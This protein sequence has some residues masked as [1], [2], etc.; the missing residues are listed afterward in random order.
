MK[1]TLPNGFYTAL[2]TPL[3]ENGNILPES[4][5]VQIQMQ[6][7]AGAAGFLVLGS[8]GMQASVRHDQCV[9]AVAT[10][11][12]V[13]D[14]WSAK[15]EKRPILLAGVMDNS[16]ARVLD[17]IKM[18][19][20]LSVDGVVATTPFYGICGENALEKFFLQIA[21]QSAFPLYLYDLPTVTKMKITWPLVRKLAQHPN[22]CGIKTADLALTRSLWLDD[23]I[24]KT[25]S[26]IFS[27]LDVFDVVS[28]FGI[29]RFLDGMFACCPQTTKRMFELFAEG[30]LEEGSVLLNQILDL[31]DTMFR[32]NIFPAFTAAMNLLGCPGDHAPDYETASPPE[33]LEVIR[34]KLVEM[35]E[36]GA[37]D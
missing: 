12:D 37:R 3:D 27:G 23:S 31:R 11:A 22:I 29:T 14:Q 21:D 8:M 4:L 19:S 17:R 25:F 24:R 10:A 1:T 16:V 35:K 13:L 20:G 30:R 18:L 9:V 34:R 28:A 7:Q 32:Y 15:H 5:A 36:L 26:T 33:A 2:G 6:Q